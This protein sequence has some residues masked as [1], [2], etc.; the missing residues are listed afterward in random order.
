MNEEKKLYIFLGILAV[1]I[2][3]IL[4]VNYINERGSKKYLESFESAISSDKQQIILV[5]R[6]NCVY[7][8]LFTP[9]L[10]YMSESYGFEYMYVNTNEIST[11]G[12][13]TVLEKLNIDKENFGTPHLSLVKSG[14]IIDEIAGYVDENELLQFLK[15]NGY[16]P[17]DANLP[18]RNI[19]YS[20]Y[21]EIINSDTQQIV[22]IGQSGCKYCMLAKPALLSIASNYNIKINYFNMTSLQESDNSESLTQEFNS[23]LDYLNNDGWGTPLMLIVKNGEVISASNGFISEETY[24]KFLKSQGIIGDLSE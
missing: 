6:D 22:V 10:D 1:F 15:N 16:A 4:G 20:E 5:G 14:N 2:I 17:E 11:K 3:G 21:K 8:Q 12:L 18:I 7:C 24:V 19:S 13:N 9:L 23:S